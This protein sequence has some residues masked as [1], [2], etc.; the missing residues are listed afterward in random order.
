M[1][2]VTRLYRARTLTRRGLYHALVGICLGNAWCLYTAAPR[3]AELISYA[4]AQDYGVYQVSL[5]TTLD[6][7]AATIRGILTDYVHIYRLNHSI[8]ES[9]I[10]PPPHESVVRVRTV[11]NAC[12]LIFCRD[13]T[14]V[15]DIRELAPGVL[16]AEIVPQLSSVKSGATVWQIQ[17][18]GNVTR[19]TYDL[20][21]EPGFFIPPLI[22]AYFVKQA[23][24]KQILATLQ[25]LEA[26]ARVKQAQTSSAGMQT[27]S[28]Q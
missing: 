25:N 5:E 18:E 9:E 23:L 28:A 19:L 3:A 27:R 14:R 1:H 20:A 6:A 13:I 10:L 2:R 4:V 22:G 16:Y 17:A 7:P 8:I 15:E 26:I 24:R 21:L 11:I 12:V